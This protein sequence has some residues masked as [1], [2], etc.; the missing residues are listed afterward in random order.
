MRQ[1]G[2][3]HFTQVGNS[4][5]TEPR[6]GMPDTGW[7]D[8]VVPGASTGQSAIITETPLSIGV[9]PLLFP[10]AGKL[11]PAARLLG[12]DLGRAGSNYFFPV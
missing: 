10:R 5:V 7:L 11:S 12:Q 8:G 6:E 9:V 3:P 2:R 4:S 1:S